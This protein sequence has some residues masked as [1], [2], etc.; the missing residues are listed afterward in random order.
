MHAVN[1]DQS[2]Q[3]QIWMAG[4]KYNIMFTSDLVLDFITTKINTVTVCDRVFSQQAGSGNAS[5]LTH[6]LRSRYPGLF[7]KGM[8]IVCFLCKDRQWGGIM[9]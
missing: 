4:Y 2:L 6:F 9:G 1:P 8:F 7:L 5:V 3:K